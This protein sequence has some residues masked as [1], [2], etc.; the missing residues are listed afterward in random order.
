V[1][2]ILLT[3]GRRIVFALAMMDFF[4]VSLALVALGLVYKGAGD[5]TGLPSGHLAILAGFVPFQ[6]AALHAFGLQ[7]PTATFQAWR[8]G[9]RLAIA[10]SIG[11]IGLGLTE[12]F[13]GLTLRPGPLLSYLGVL[14]CALFAVR[15]VVLG[16]AHPRSPGRRLAV[17]GELSAVLELAGRVRAEPFAGYSI[18]R[19]CVPPSQLPDSAELDV[20][21]ERI[22]VTDE[23]GKLLGS[24]DFDAIAFDPHCD[25]FN[26]GDLCRLAELSG[27]GIAVY[28]LAA[29]SKGVAGR[30]PR[31]SLDAARV[32]EAICARN[33]SDVAYSAMKRGF[34]VTIA[35]LALAAA[36]L[37]MLLIALIIRLESSGPALLPQPR[38]GYRGR[39]FRCFKFRTMLQSAPKDGPAWT[40]KDDPRI[41]RVGRYLRKLRFDE[42]PQLVNVL[43]GE[44]S[45]VGPRPV[46]ATISDSVRAAIPLYHI[47]NTIRPGITGWAQVKQGYAGGRDSEVAKLRYDLYYIENRSLTL[48]C[49]IL[50]MT[51][52]IVLAG[53]G[54]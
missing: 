13:C 16:W 37:P 17:V 44:M 35:S 27:F 30:F 1:T 9:S 28:N 43:K 29:L 34:D 33:A 14:F 15:F 7:E 22:E 51:A 11:L 46:L 38:V 39:I 47:R 49:L 12:I 6:L 25:N 31:S 3:R 32:A 8:Y 5:T 50:L 26:D 2:A 19:V 52:H 4:F 10:L 23:V 53:A 45:I 21:G 41:T 54:R 18:V 24:R 36:A 40:A 48:D 42:L 20:A